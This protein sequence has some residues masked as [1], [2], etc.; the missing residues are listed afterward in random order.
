MNKVVVIAVKLLALL[1][2]VAVLLNVSGL[3]DVDDTLMIVF[4]LLVM[5]ISVIYFRYK[6][7]YS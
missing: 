6:R 7:R 3:W 1:T 4:Q 5:A 2:F